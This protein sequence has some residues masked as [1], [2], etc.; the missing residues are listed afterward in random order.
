M[1]YAVSFALLLS[2]TIIFTQ[3][4][5]PLEYQ[6]RFAQN[7]LE[8]SEPEVPYRW[9]KHTNTTFQAYDFA[10]SIR[11]EKLKIRYLFVPDDD[12][13]ADLIPHLRVPRMAMHLASN[14]DGSYMSAHAI[15]PSLLDS[16][17]HADWGQVFFFRPKPLF[18]SA[19]DCQM[20][21]FYREG[22]G[23]FYV[24]MLFDEPPMT[25]PERAKLVRFTEKGFI[26]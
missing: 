11:K 2:T 6:L 17:Y 16:V 7:E 15:E 1:R 12:S 13:H 10:I 3:E 14:D 22:I 20:L 26:D 24:F 5:L 25:L 9:Q 18:S 21:A 23:L 4:G 8:W 19:K